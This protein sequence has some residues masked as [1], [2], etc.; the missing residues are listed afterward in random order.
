M[1]KYY[2]LSLRDTTNY[3][4]KIC[5]IHRK[6]YGEIET[7]GLLVI[8]LPILCIFD[9]IDITIKNRILSGNGFDF[10]EKIIE[11]NESMRKYIIKLTGKREDTEE[12]YK[13]SIEEI[14]KVYKLAFIDDNHYGCYECYI[15]IPADF[16]NKC[17]RI[18]NNV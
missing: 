6:Y 16:K 14:R 1:Q 11:E 8:F 17:L 5:L 4:Q 15:D 10:V 7:C 12:N 18:C 3:F 9:I 2:A 13:A